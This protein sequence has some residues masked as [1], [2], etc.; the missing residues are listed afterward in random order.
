[1]P[2]QLGIYNEA[3]AHMGERRLATS[4][5]AREP[6]RVLDSLWPDVVAYCLAQGLWRFAVRVVQIDNDSTVNVQFGY[7]Y[8]F[9]KP[10]DWVHTYVISTEP[11]LDPPLLQYED[12]GGYW[13]GNLTPLYAKYISND[14]TYGQ[15][16]GAWTPHFEDYVTL[17]L[18]R[19]A[20]FRITG[21]KSWRQ[22]LKKDEDHARRVA[23]A[24]EALGDPPGLPPV[25]MWARA[26]RGN[27]GPYG[28]FIG[29]GGAGSSD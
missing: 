25:S 28:Q 11:L 29:G 4:S 23:K 20:A 9:A 24:E 16:L 3:L 7:L 21:D 10:G 6:K 13:Y 8:A 19:Y 18:A 15:N 1:M 14:P 27:F 17:R 22:E 26:R 2:T 12:A 5:E